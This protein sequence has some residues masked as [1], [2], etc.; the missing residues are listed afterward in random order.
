[1]SRNTSIVTSLYVELRKRFALGLR[2]LRVTPK[3]LGGPEESTST[4]AAA[5]GKAKFY[6]TGCAGRHSGL[7][8]EP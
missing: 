1:M 2:T 6:C 3:V 4:A 5:P 8:Q 7:G